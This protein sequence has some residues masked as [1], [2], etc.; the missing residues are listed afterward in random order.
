MIDGSEEMVRVV[1]FRDIILRTKSIALD[2]IFK[3]GCSG[4]H[5]NLAGQ[6]VLVHIVENLEAAFI[7][8]GNVEQ[9]QVECLFREK[10]EGALAFRRLEDK[11]SARL[12]N[13]PNRISQLLIGVDQ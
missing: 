11:I 9:Y 6:M 3:P 2:R 10:G 1:R 5:D 13:Q 8:K 4:Y 7:R 12:Q